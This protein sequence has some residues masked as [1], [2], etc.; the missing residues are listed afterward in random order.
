[1]SAVP[2]II[3]V[4]QR[5]P[6]VQDRKYLDY[7][8]TQ[9]CIVT[10]HSGSADLPLVEPAHLRLLGAGGMGLKPSD[11]RTLP[12]YWELHRRQSTEGELASWLRCANE[13]P[14]FLA[15]MLIEV[16]ESRYEKWVRGYAESLKP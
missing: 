16:S 13:Y 10:G 8:R 7:L 9:P 11:A 15:R 5:Q 14:D 1:M 6:R 4:R 12:L 3:P 2:N